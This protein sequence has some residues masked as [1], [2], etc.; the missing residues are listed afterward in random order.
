M[1]NEL[2]IRDQITEDLQGAIRGGSHG[3][4]VVPKL[5]KHALEQRAWEERLIRV[6]KRTFPGFPTFAE[7]V[8]S[9]PPEGL[10]TTIEL[11]QR[12]ISDDPKT[13]AML[14]KATTGKPGAHN[15]NVIRKRTRQGNSRAYTLDRLERERPDLFARVTT[16]ELSANAAALE[17]GWR[18]KLSPFDRA[19]RAIEALS[20]ADRD[21][22][23]M[24]FQQR[25]AA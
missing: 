9:R 10:G 6:T 12:L 11:V 15:N 2:I 14:R 24:L 13:L 7:Y 5:I 23:F 1:P 8:V 17:A 18:K 25:S 22:L 4:D 16:R 21:R 20:P 19:L 3:L